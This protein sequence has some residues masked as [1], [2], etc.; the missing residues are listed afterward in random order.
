ML[1]FLRV[2]NLLLK[3]SNYRQ[4]VIFIYTDISL[5]LDQL[6]LYF[7][8]STSG[9]QIPKV[10]IGFKSC[11]MISGKTLEL[12]ASFNC[13]GYINWPCKCILSLNLFLLLSIDIYGCTT[14][15]LSTA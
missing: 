14:I 15:P 4:D 8:N 13:S 9:M 10:N 11:I 7:Q 1:P 2:Q 5:A 6:A 3:G 12:N